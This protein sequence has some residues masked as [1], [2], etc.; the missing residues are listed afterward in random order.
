MRRKFL[1]FSILVLLL[2]LR[3]AFR[4][5]VLGQVIDLPDYFSE[6]YKF[7]SDLKSVTELHSWILVT[8]K[9]DTTSEF[10]PKHMAVV[11]VENKMVFL[12]LQKSDIKDE[13]VKEEYSGNGYHL[14]LVYK[15][16][17][18]QNHAALY[19]GYFTIQHSQQRSHYTVVGTSNGY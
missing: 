7:G 1:L 15:E 5:L 9:V 14:D 4:E 3:C 18:I 11:A 17:K 2:N 8:G 6:N 19:E 16:K 13:E 12:L 10:P